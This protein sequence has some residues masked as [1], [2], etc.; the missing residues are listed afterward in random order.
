MVSMLFLRLR[1]H[2]L[3]YRL[4]AGWGPEYVAYLPGLTQFR[5]LDSHHASWRG[6]PL[7]N[8]MHYWCFCTEFPSNR[9]PGRLPRALFQAP[10]ALMEQIVSALCSWPSIATHESALCSWET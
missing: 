3:A 2:G 10:P 5:V 6:T 7:Q 8:C 4:Q 1:L 9:L